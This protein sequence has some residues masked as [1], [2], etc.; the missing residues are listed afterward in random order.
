MSD[1]ENKK[2]HI[3][4][5]GVIPAKRTTPETVNEALE[6]LREFLRRYP[7]LAE[8]I[9]KEREKWLNEDGRNSNSRNQLRP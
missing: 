7:F 6:N 4:L 8:E 9:M 1:N 5:K 3:V 2:E